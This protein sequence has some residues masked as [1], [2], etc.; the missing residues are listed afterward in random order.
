MVLTLIALISMLIQ[1]AAADFDQGVALPRFEKPL[2]HVAAET[3]LET[4]ARLCAGRNPG[5]EVDHVL[6]DNGIQFVETNP[7][8]ARGGLSRPLYLKLQNRSRA[9]CE[10][11]ALLSGQ[12]WQRIAA[13]K[14]AGDSFF[15]GAKTKYTASAQD[16]Y[17]IFWKSKEAE[18]SRDKI[19]AYALAVRSDLAADP[20]LPQLARSWEERLGAAAKGLKEWE[21]AAISSIKERH[22]IS[23]WDEVVQPV[24]TIIYSPGAEPARAMRDCDHWSVYL[25]RGA[26]RRCETLGSFLDE[27][28]GSAG[29]SDWEATLSELKQGHAYLQVDASGSQTLISSDKDLTPE[30]AA[31][32]EESRPGDSGHSPVR[33]TAGDY[34]PPEAK[35]SWDEVVYACGQLD[36]N[37]ASGN[38]THAVSDA[39]SDCLNKRKPLCQL[40]QAQRLKI[41]QQS[42]LSVA[43]GREAI[44]MDELMTTCP[45]RGGEVKQQAEYVKVYECW[46]SN[47]KAPPI[48]RC[49]AIFDETMALSDLAGELQPEQGGGRAQAYQLMQGLAQKHGLQQLCQKDILRFTK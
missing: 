46:A 34:F 2:R 24:S 17:E 13:S 49:K 20:E 12:T 45:L 21:T 42:C 38:N 32:C 9:L 40:D 25:P 18:E 22:G 15:A 33:A 27:I 1:P 5:F 11:R 8:C 14:E 19:G 39:A 31:A 26:P 6:Q 7:G 37:S 35:Q 16:N 43:S 29:S 48:V 47:Q 4:A 23:N 30:T 44:E 28:D 36:A 41:A 10:Y 3:P